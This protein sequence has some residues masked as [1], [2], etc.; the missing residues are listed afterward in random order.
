MTATFSGDHLEFTQGSLSVPFSTLLEETLLKIH[1]QKI[2][3]APNYGLSAPLL[4][5]GAISLFK[6]YEPQF[7]VSSFYA[8]NFIDSSVCPSFTAAIKK[9]AVVY[10]FHRCI[11]RGLMA[12]IRTEGFETAGL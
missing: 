12:T 6:P 4:F 7:T 9:A 5:I 10:I 3:C 11:S 1:F 8:L 2:Y